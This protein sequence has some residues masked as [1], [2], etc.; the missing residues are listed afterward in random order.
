[1][2]ACHG[3]GGM[4]NCGAG[5]ED[6]GKKKIGT[7]I[8]EASHTMFAILSQLD[9]KVG[10]RCESSEPAWARRAPFPR[11]DR[12]PSCQLAHA[13]QAASAAHAP[14]AH[15]L[16][17]AT[18]RLRGADRVGSRGCRSARCSGRL[19]C[20]RS[21]IPATR[22][23]RSMMTP[24]WVSTACRTAPLRSTTV[25]HVSLLRAL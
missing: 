12:S 23:R 20:T 21:A 13:R 24:S 22:T 17:A 4:R 18:M 5:G 3:P 10:G 9:S 6:G 14:L 1:M 7:K 15:P 2:P 19:T 25:G 8:V 16:R 11:N